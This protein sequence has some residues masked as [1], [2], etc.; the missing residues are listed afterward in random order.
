MTDD[1]HD[2][3]F[4]KISFL[5]NIPS[6]ELTTLPCKLQSLNN[7]YKVKHRVFFVFV[8]EKEDNTRSL[9]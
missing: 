9:H 3:L 6:V 5:V 7:G 1:R 8:F 2:Y 4:G